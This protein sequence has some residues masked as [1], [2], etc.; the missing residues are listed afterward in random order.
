MI[1]KP[2]QQVSEQTPREQSLYSV[3]QFAEVE[4][5]FTTGALRNM[6][7]KADV[8]HASNGVIP[9]NGLLACGAIVRIGRKV[10]IHRTK[11]LEWVQR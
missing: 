1:N 5:A 6:V 7:F 9:G 8:R 11:F 2:T 4:P 10:L 3:A